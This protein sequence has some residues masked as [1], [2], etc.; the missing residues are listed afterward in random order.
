[1]QL[2]KAAPL[3]APVDAA[4]FSRLPASAV[5]VRA[6]STAAPKTIALMVHPPSFMLLFSHFSSIGVARPPRPKREPISGGSVHLRIFPV[7]EAC[8]TFGCAQEM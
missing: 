7:R 1:M 8:A 5:E 6:A 3:L 4:Q 2:L